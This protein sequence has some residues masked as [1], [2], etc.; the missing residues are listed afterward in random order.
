MA[1][2]VREFLVVVLDEPM[3]LHRGCHG[4]DHEALMAAFTS[5]Y[6]SGRPPH[7]MDLRATAL[8]MA[9]SGFEDAGRIISLAKRRP[10]RIGTH[11]ATLDLEPGHGICIAD[12]SGPGHWS[13]W[14][15]PTQ[16]VA[17]VTDVQE[18]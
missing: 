14:G 10:D 13:I 17:F 11:V 8:H 15:V 4:D 1:S 6:E 12:T 3:T 9:V 2:P 16:L 18:V 5:N 7:P